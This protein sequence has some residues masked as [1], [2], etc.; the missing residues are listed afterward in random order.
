MFG[1]RYIYTHT[2]MYTYICAYMYILLKTDI[3]FLNFSIQISHKINLIHQAYIKKH[4]KTDYIHAT[5][6][7]DL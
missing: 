1:S 4:I 3:F 5:L 6:S 2:C 7:I